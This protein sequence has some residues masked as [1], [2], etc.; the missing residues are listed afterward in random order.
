ADAASIEDSSCLSVFYTQQATNVGISNLHDDQRK[1]SF[2]VQIAPHNAL[3][4]LEN[5]SFA[6]RQ[7]LYSEYSR[8]KFGDK[9]V[10]E[11]FAKD[12][13]ARIDQQQIITVD[14]KTSWVIVTPPYNRLVNSAVPLA[15]QVAEILGVQFVNIRS[16][17]PRGYK[18]R[19]QSYAQLKS[20]GERGNYMVFDI[21]YDAETSLHDKKVI[22]ID[23]LFN[24]GSSIDK[25]YDCLQNDYG[26]TIVDFFVVINLISDNHGLENELGRFIQ[27]VHGNGN[28]IKLLMN[29]TTILNRSTVDILFEMEHDD[30]RHA[31]SSFN[32]NLLSR[33][34]VAA[35]RYYGKDDTLQWRIRQNMEYAER[36]LE[37]SQALSTHDG[38]REIPI[39]VQFMLWL[40]NRQNEWDDHEALLNEW[41]EQWR[42]NDSLACCD[43]DSAHGIDMHAYA[44]RH[45]LALATAA[46]RELLI[47][48]AESIEDK[49]TRLRYT[50][51]LREVER[52]VYQWEDGIENP[53]KL[54]LQA[55]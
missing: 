30:F 52:L 39:E 20:Q 25:V 18:K 11:K 4:R 3:H 7:P 15:R 27:Q 6:E 42:I 43:N 17:Y 29:P 44:M 34:V 50:L 32:A 28:I 49:N 21:A 14:D 41:Y 19:S 45:D 47:D 31:C 10:I 1:R 12:L 9:D 5:P 23:D 13:A 36:F 35:Q 33:Y 51:M 40:M 8:Y 22:L 38:L 16:V 46:I 37:Q 55:A 26:A 54:H 48:Y 53:D 24:T 2:V